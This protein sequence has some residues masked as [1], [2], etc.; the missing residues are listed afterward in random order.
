MPSASPQHSP[1]VVEAEAINAA[2][3]SGQIST[4]TAISHYSQAAHSAM[5]RGGVLVASVILEECDA[6]IDR[7]PIG[8][9]HSIA[10]N[11]RAK[12]AWTRLEALDIAKA[13]A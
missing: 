12:A 10:W 13:G 9:E 11:R 3:R 8:S 6:L 2:W 1:E 5:D 4:L 7:L